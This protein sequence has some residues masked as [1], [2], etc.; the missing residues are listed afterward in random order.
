MNEV[1][2]NPDPEQQEQA[3]LEDSLRVFF[4][5]HK[6]VRQVTL[7]PKHWVTHLFR[8]KIYADALTVS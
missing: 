4:V 8:L 1:W 2:G 3:D 7:T 6:A 5:K